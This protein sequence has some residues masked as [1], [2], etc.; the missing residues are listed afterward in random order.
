MKKIF[1]LPLVLL[2]SISCTKK[3]TD[4]T[5]TPT[6]TP[7]PTPVSDGSQTASGLA[8]TFYLCNTDSSF[9]STSYAYLHI[10][11][12]SA[13][14]TYS[15]SLRFSDATSCA[16]SYATGGSELAVYSQAG[17]FTT[18][19]TAGTPSTG[20]KVTFTV[21]SSSLGTRGGTYNGNAI[22]QNLITFF[23][24]CTPAQS[25]STSV[26]Q[27][28]LSIGAASC[29][30]MVFPANGDTFTNVIYNDGNSLWAGV[31]SGQNLLRTGGSTYP[32][33]YT[34]TYIK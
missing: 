23:N 29:G 4:A 3:A 13:S 31:S 17:T 14:G 1:L 2:L 22:E 25:V 33:S 30:G 19:G 32:S 24:T 15:Y 6:P 26:D 16:N 8:G 11:T 27:T 12:L 21:T 20:T 7:T 34:Q 28:K 10:L 5:A 9:L 18:G